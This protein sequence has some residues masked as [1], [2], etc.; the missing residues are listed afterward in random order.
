MH[1]HIY[2]GLL[3]FK[4]LKNNELEIFAPPNIG[5]LVPKETNPDIG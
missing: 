3:L 2:A 1:V 4:R 5:D